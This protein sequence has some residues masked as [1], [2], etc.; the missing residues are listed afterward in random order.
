MTNTDKGRSRHFLR[1]SIFNANMRGRGTTT[2]KENP[3]PPQ[4]RHHQPSLL[5]K[6]ICPFCDSPSEM[7]GR[8]GKSISKSSSRCAGKQSFPKPTTASSPY[9]IDTTT[10]LGAEG[11]A[12][13]WCSG[14]GARAILRQR[15]R[16]H[17]KRWSFFFFP[18][19]NEREKEKESTPFVRKEGGGAYYSKGLVRVPH[20]VRNTERP[21]V[22]RTLARALTPTVS[23][24]RFSMR[25]SLKN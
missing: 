10:L 9:Y 2:A 14:T 6:E 20:Q 12:A 15:L 22:S 11:V 17:P 8:A 3:H 16:R 23:K 7:A 5:D 24:G 18:L 4:D 21:T 1:A 25:I 19:T 13:Q